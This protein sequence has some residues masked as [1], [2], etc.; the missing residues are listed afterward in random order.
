METKLISSPVTGGQAISSQREQR[1]IMESKARQSETNSVA[2]DKRASAPVDLNAAKEAAK[3]KAAEDIEGLVERLNTKA[4][5]SSHTLRFSIDEKLGKAIISV[6]DRDTDEV[7]RQIPPET[8]M[9]IA[10]AF[11]EVTAGHL[12]TE[13]A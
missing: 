4:L 9:Q 1:V 10:E 5:T 2:L 11:D 7:I 6:V 13:Q 12:L 3:A 8:A